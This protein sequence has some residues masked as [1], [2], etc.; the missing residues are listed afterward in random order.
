MS[1]E[2]SEK[3]LRDQIARAAAAHGKKIVW[4]EEESLLVLTQ[5]LKEIGAARGQRS[6]ERSQLIQAI[7]R[8]LPGVNAVLDADEL[9][10][11]LDAAKKP[12]D[13][14]ALKKGGQDIT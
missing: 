13:A 4:P 11:R 6:K 2:E 9:D 10:R 3:G 1:S 14:R 8:R 12:K 7:E 5:R